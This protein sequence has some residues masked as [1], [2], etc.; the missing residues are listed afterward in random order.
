MQKTIPLQLIIGYK[1]GFPLSQYILF[2]LPILLGLIGVFYKAN[3]IGLLVYLILGFL[4][5]YC[6]FV[7]YSC[8]IVI[9]NHLMT[10]TYMAPWNKNLVLDISRYKYFHYGQSFYSFSTSNGLS[11]NI[12]TLFYCN[13]L[14]ILSDNKTDAQLEIKINTRMF[15]FKRLINLLEKD[16]KLK[17][18]ELK[19]SSAIIW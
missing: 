16:M 9:D 19:G 11:F 8:K 13:D 7:R 4:F 15:A 1:S 2:I 10:L 12:A 17:K 5:F 18:A 14:L 3:I 6:F